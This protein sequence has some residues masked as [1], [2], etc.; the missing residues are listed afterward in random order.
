MKRRTFLSASAALLASTGAGC[1]QRDP[2]EA[3][4]AGA[5]ANPGTVAAPLFR[6]R[7]PSGREIDRRVD[8]PDLSISDN[9]PSFLS[10]T[11]ADGRLQ[12]TIERFD[13]DRE[14][15]L[16]RH[17]A[18]DGLRVPL[19]SRRAGIMEGRAP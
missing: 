1:S 18:R 14:G 12:P 7:D 19:E 17:G 13:Y 16:R 4:D 15:L 11:E 5:V 6:Y 2:A 3:G 10:V 9:R 8:D